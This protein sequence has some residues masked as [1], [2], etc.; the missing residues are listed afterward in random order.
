MWKGRQER[1]REGGRE[2]WERGREDRRKSNS[3]SS[4]KH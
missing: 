4:K 3:V 2:N 1:E